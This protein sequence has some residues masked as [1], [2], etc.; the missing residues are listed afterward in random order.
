MA[1]QQPQV[2]EAPPFMLVD[3][4][5]LEIRAG[6]LCPVCGQ[7]KIDYDSILNLSCPACGYTLAGCFT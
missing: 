2:K 4:E 1:D 7:E 5:P 3:I 6:D